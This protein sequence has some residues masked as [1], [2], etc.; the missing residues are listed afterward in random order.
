MSRE[1]GQD[2]GADK[3]QTFARPVFN[4]LEP[5][6]EITLEEKVEDYIVKII[7]QIFNDEYIKNFHKRNA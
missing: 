7:T 5:I 1:S 6:K 4:I 2:S 3:P